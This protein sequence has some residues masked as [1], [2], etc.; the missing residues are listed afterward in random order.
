MAIAVIVLVVV[1]A[2]GLALADASDKID[3]A[4]RKTSDDNEG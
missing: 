4:I 3:E 2:L 1:F